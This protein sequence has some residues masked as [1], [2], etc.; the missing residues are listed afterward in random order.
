M[1][2]RAPLPLAIYQCIATCPL[3]KIVDGYQDKGSFYSLSPANLRSFV[4]V[5]DVLESYCMRLAKTLLTSDDCTQSSCMNFIRR[6][7]L[8]DMTVVP[9]F[10]FWRSEWGELFCQ[11]CTAPLKVKCGVARKKAW[12]ELPAAFGFDSWAEVGKS[13]DFPSLRIR[14]CD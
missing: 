4:R 5:K 7:W 2:L 12:N 13:G 8:E 9:P 11:S 3:T 14:T 10:D 6:L 1:D